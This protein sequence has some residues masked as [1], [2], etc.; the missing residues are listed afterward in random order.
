VTQQDTDLEHKGP[1]KR[2]HIELF[3]V[4]PTLDPAEISAALGLESHFAQRV[5]DPR[6]TP[7]ARPLAGSYRDTRW[8]H[9]VECS[10][11]DQWFA[12]EV[13]SLLDRLEPHKAFFANLRPTGGEASLIIQFLGDG[14]LSDEIPH[15]TLVKLVE[16]GLGIGIECFVDSQL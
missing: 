10:T 4:H 13:M 11:T 9:C 8:R 15:A 3:I 14:Y 1:A 16:L 2:F 12:A 7:N 6:K 5:G